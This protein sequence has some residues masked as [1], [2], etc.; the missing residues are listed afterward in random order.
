[1]ANLFS[2]IG[3]KLKAVKPAI[4]LDTKDIEDQ[5]REALRDVMDPDLH[6]DIVS[7]G[8]VKSIQV[9]SGKASLVIELTTPACPAKEMLKQQIEAKALGIEGVESCVIE[10]TANMSRGNVKINAEVQAALGQVRN[11]IAVASGKGGVGKST[12]TVNLAMSLAKS[13]SKVGI[14]DADVHG[15]S[16]PLMTGVGQPTETI[17]KMV[18]PPVSHGM[19]VISV[20]MFTPDGKANIMRGPMTSQI[21]RQFLTQIAWGELDY[22][23][24]DYPPGTGDIQLSLSQMAPITGAVLVTT[25][26]EVALVD[27]RKAVS[28][29][30]TTKVPILG[31]VETMSYFLCDG[32]DKKH[33]IF[34]E[35]GGEKVAAEHGV[36]LL[37]KIPLDP[38][39]AEGGDSGQPIVMIDGH[40]SQA[41]LE[42]AGGLASQVSIINMSTAGLSQ[43]S[44]EWNK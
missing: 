44:L 30:N 11:I 16:I 21:I 40:A 28:M 31:V 35:G 14:L 10:F 7:L 20:E 3:E 34:R 27:V 36:P 23:L 2:S 41:Y 24:I 6:K 17:D 22:L 18:V 43:F 5:I 15:P 29:F 12:T 8:F 33:A 19:K 26:Q 32:C 42:A 1:M 4:S 25:P 38:R 13:G 39:V 37:G 9:K